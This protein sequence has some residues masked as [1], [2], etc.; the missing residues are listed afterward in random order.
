MLLSLAAKERRII[1]P[2][3]TTDTREG[4]KNAARKYFFP[5]QL[6]ELRKTAIISGNG[7]RIAIVIAV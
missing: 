5:G 6:S 1:I 3:T 7:I 4:I 2:V